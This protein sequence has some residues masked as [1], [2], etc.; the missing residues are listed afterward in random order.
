MQMLPKSHREPN[1]VS[2]LPASA[3]VARYRVVQSNR[4][5]CFVLRIECKWNRVCFLFM[6][7]H[8][9]QNRGSC[10][11]SLTYYSVIPM[12]VVLRSVILKSFLLA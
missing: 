8:P 3:F 7:L 1:E 4:C 5:F 11:S 9:F 12:G 6:M 2:F 10:S